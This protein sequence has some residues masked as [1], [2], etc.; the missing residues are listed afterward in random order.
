MRVVGA[1]D[2]SVHDEAEALAGLVGEA[3]VADVV[4]ADT[5]I[6]W[7]LDT[8][9]DANVVMEDVVDAEGGGEVVLHV[10]GDLVGRIAV[11]RAALAHVGGLPG[12]IVGRLALEE[13]GASVLS[14][15]QRLV[16]LEVLV[17]EAVERDVVAGAVKAAICNCSL[18]A[19]MNEKY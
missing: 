14:V 8:A 5:V 18:N 13:V 10:V 9:L 2:Q 19:V 17:E 15:P 3:V 12:R 1:P 16:L 4:Q 6:G 7:H 11:A